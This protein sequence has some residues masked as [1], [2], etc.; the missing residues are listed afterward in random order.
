LYKNLSLSSG[1][2]SFVLSISPQIKP[3]QGGP[4]SNS[5]A[6]FFSSRLIKV[7]PS[8]D[9]CFEDCA[10]KLTTFINVLKSI[11]SPSGL[12]ATRSFLL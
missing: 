3:K 10:F 12:T 8:S 1:N 11:S 9:N 2:F 5:A 7:A 6:W 4:S